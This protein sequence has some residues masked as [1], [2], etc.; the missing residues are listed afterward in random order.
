[1]AAIIL[2]GLG[3]RISW[4]NKTALWCYEAESS[5]N[6]LTIIGTGIPGWKYVGFP[7]VKNT[8]TKTWDENPEYEFRD[9]TYSDRGV[10]VYHG[11]LPLYTIAAS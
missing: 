2:L 11:C 8:L 9:S 7:I 3:L 1:V 4:M 5:I 6:A 10:V